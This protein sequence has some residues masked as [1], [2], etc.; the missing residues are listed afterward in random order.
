MSG[1]KL[2]AVDFD[3]F[4]GAELVNTGASTEAQRELWT[5]SQLGSDASC[6][7]N[8]S[9]SV[10]LEGALDVEALNLALN[11]LTQRHESL[12]MTFTPDGASFV[13][14]QSVNSG[15]RRVDLSNLGQ[16][17]R[18]A[19]LAKI[20]VE[21]VETAFDLGTGPLC[22]FVLVKMA[23]DRHVLIISAHHVVC[24]GWSLAVMLAD[25]GKLYTARKNRTDFTA[26]T[27]RYSDYAAAQ[28]AYEK[29]ADYA[30]DE[31]FWVK[32]FSS[33]PDPLELPLDRPRPKV[34]TY[35]SRRIDHVLEAPLV[36]AVKKL[37]AK[38]S[39][40]FF[41]T[42]LA[43][44]GA[45]LHR[46]THQDE[47]VI[48]IPS[49]GQSATGMR[50]LVGHCVNALPLR[51]ATQRAEP[52]AALLSRVRGVM[53]DGV[54]HQRLTFGSLVKKLGVTRDPSRLPLVSVLFNVDQAVDGDKLGFDG[55]RASFASNPRHYEN[56]EI[57]INAAEYKGVVTLECQY[58][59]DLFDDAT[60]RRWLAAYETLLRDW[61]THPDRQVG[62]LDIGAKLTRDETSADFPKVEAH[63]L[64]FAQADKTPDAVAI[65]QGNRKLTYKEL[66]DQARALADVLAENGVGDET[67]VGIHLNRTPEMVV[68]VLAVQEA[69]GAY[70]PL[71]PA[72]P[73]ERL[74]FM[75]ADSKAPVVITE[76][77]LSHTFAGVGVKQLL[78]DQLEP[79]APRAERPKRN[80][81]EAL[82]Y[83]LYTSGS[84]GKP[85]G[86]A[87]P[88][89][90][91]VNFLVSMQKEPG[92]AASDRLLA[93]TTL[94]F[95]IAGLELFL[96]LITGAR[97]VLATKEQTTDGAEL[98]RLIK[99]EGVTYMQ[100]TPSTWRLL[101]ASGWTGSPGFTALCGGE[102][103]SPE[104]A[105]D[106][107][108]KVG[109]LWNMYG[110][111]ETNVCTY[112]EIPATVEP[113][114][115]APY[116]IGKACEQFRARVVDETGVDV[117]R[118]QEGELVMAGPGVMQGYWNLAS[119]TADAFFVDATGE[120]WYRT[121]DLVTEDAGGVFTYV[122]RRDRMV[123]RRGYRIE[124]GEIESGLYKH[125]DVREAAV[126]ALKDAD[127][128]VRI[129]AF[130]ASN[131][132]TLSL[133]TMKQFCAQ[134]LPNY[135]SPDAF[136]FIDALPKT[137]TDKVDYQRL[138]AMG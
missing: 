64:V 16:T 135:M 126:V 70:V 128:G 81:P 93:V 24:D 33:Q 30:A 116:P 138:V 49:A 8:E 136:G 113:D 48:A 36:D 98:L 4:A 69:G 10:V 63:Q 134:V 65:V 40:S 123:K 80:K 11:D 68:A 7:F 85:K 90:A 102:A 3:P 111:T 22:R 18:D 127:G 103:V 53:L 82:A 28:A 71:D 46:L 41:T 92:L 83:V 74:Q 86:V 47:V 43:G 133:I 108:S 55:L 62:A 35:A 9:V 118:G 20:K 45:L 77:A 34:K 39:S 25:L 101:L 109:A 13:V 54:E 21:E 89:R 61:S 105:R 58:N 96:P 14:A 52:A 104:L 72:F 100:A 2:E 78:V 12:R 94:S 107:G 119:R 76:T 50:E 99:D 5:A 38:S 132:P 73:A 125:P 131:G 51:F 112:H 95:D 44:F 6:A 115:T 37:G 117:A 122:G 27:V 120:R 87:V 106:V 57:F 15:P 97:I 17:E 91:L 84:T 124:L 26:K 31:A 137:S 75:I 130:V 32:Q 1:P 19:A 114:R 23:S 121:G 88:H 42:L 79:K 66:A 67:F 129:K 59:T 56:F 60:M 110:P 29:S